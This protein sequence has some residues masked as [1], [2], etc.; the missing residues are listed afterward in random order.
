[1]SFT[2]KTLDDVYKFSLSLYD[3]LKANSYE[4]QATILEELV[5]DCFEKDSSA[6]VAHRKAYQEVYDKTDN[7]PTEYK[8]ALENSLELLK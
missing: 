3:Y 5:D 6:I 4:E 7:L 1:M 2:I 8:K